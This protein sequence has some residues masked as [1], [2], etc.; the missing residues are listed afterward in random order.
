MVS[1]ILS[2][3]AL[4]LAP[5]AAPCRPGSRVGSSVRYGQIAMQAAMSLFA[6]TAVAAA[7]LH[8]PISFGF[9]FTSTISSVDEAAG[10]VCHRLNHQVRLLSRRVCHS[11][12]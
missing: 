1:L 5:G 7:N 4:G 2:F 3:A 6:L 8:A 9:A 11:H 10:A 12:L